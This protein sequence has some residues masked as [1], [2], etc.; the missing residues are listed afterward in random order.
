MREKY[1]KGVSTWTPKRWY[2][3]Q[4]MFLSLIIYCHKFSLFFYISWKN[5]SSVFKIFARKHSLTIVKILNLCIIL[6]C[7]HSYHFFPVSI[8]YLQIAMHQLY[9]HKNLFLVKYRKQIIVNVF[10]WF[11]INYKN[12]K[13]K[14]FSI[15]LMIN[16]GLKFWIWFI[17]ILKEIK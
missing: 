9:Y 16:S 8:H 17:R 3:T 13:S 6:S 7:T 12:L 10:I 2:T 5:L 15:F 1:S 14:F 11:M 4:K